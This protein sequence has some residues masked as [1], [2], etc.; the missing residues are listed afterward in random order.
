LKLD[1]TANLIW[2]KRGACAL[3]TY[4]EFS[5]HSSSPSSIDLLTWQHTICP[6][7]CSPLLRYTSENAHYVRHDITVNWKGIH[8]WIEEMH[9]EWLLQLSFS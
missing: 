2:T 4:T 8:V 1:T 3:V 6:R 5:D 9:L 7:I